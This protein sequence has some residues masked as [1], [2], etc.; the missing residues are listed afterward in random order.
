MTP[1]DIIV[2]HVEVDSPADDAAQPAELSRARYKQALHIGYVEMERIVEDIILSEFHRIGEY[3][4]ENGYKAEIIVFDTNCELEGKLYVCGAGLKIERGFMKNAIVYTGDPHQFK[5]VLQ[6]QNYAMRTTEQTVDYHKLT[7]NWFHKRVKDFL[8]KSVRDTDWSHLD[9]LFSDD[10]EVLEAP[11]S[12]KIKNE[13]GYFNEVAKAD[14][15]D[16][17]FIIGS[18]ITKKLGSEPDLL[19]IDKNG[20]EVC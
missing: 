17:A 4:L 16:E 5:F 8:K 6:T 10:W 18:D 3:L 7:P 15:I 2:E 13:Y 19:L 1:P 12:V 20:R 11:F 14:T 9:D